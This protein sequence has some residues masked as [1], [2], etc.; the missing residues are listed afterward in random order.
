M[1]VEVFCFAYSY[2]LV[3]EC[4]MS[5]VL[6]A[7][8]TWLARVFQ[9]GDLLVYL[10]ICPMLLPTAFA[11]FYNGWKCSMDWN[12]VPVHEVTLW[13]CARQTLC[14]LP[15]CT[16]QVH[17]TN[18]TYCVHQWT[19]CSCF[20]SRGCSV[21][22]NTHLHTYVRTCTYIPAYICTC[23]YIPTYICTCTYVP[24]P[25]PWLVYS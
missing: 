5:V 13:L 14:Y 20:T 10:C 7:E 19:K 8:S 2:H 16:L 11:E 1:F 4:F 24:P 3:A 9:S 25:P 21:N 18:S 23:T 12:A 17:S 15:M 22:L 6:T